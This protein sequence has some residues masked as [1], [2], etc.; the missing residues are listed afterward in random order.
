VRHALATLAL[1]VLVGCGEPEPKPA[2]PPPPPPP[3]AERE[4]LEIPKPASKM[5]EIA[6]WRATWE[7][8]EKAPAKTLLSGQ[9][10][11]WTLFEAEGIKTRDGNDGWKLGYFKKAG[12]PDRLEIGAAEYSTAETA[13]RAYA[14]TWAGFGSKDPA[15][16]PETGF[17]RPYETP[18]A[19]PGVAKKDVLAVRCLV[20]D[21]FL[22]LF[23]R[24]I[25]D[26]AALEK[27]IPDET[28]RAF[29]EAVM[30]GRSKLPAK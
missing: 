5:S 19:T 9:E 29:V 18:S 3:G 24:P 8:P 2:P 22:I 12:D 23:K 28:V 11:P 13:R 25:A 16:A 14:E 27:A 26:A 7:D 30:P 6:S 10:Q 17:T 4:K 1:I 15:P 20:V 21:R